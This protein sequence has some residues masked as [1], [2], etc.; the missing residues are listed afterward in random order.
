MLKKIRVPNLALPRVQAKCKA[1]LELADELDLYGPRSITQVELTKLLGNQTKPIG[2]YLRQGLERFGSYRP[3]ESGYSY[4]TNSEFCNHLREHLA[5]PPAPIL[6]V[7]KRV[8]RTFSPLKREELKKSGHRYYPW[9]TWMKSEKLEELFIA[10]YGQMHRYDIEAAQPTIVL[11]LYDQRLTSL[12]KYS[13]KHKV[14]TWRSYVNDRSTFRQTLAEHIF[15]PVQVV[16]DVLQS[17]TNGGY[18]TTSPKNPICRMLGI[19]STH[20]LLQHELYQGLIRDYRTMRSVLF[21]GEPVKGLSSRLYHS[22]E[23]VEDLIMECI[24][25]KLKVD[26]WFIHDG[27]FTHTR[28]QK[29]ELEAHVKNTLGFTIRLDEKSR[30]HSRELHV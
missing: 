7:A 27:F 4:R 20:R 21:P 10:Q 26:A 6:E 11:Q 13:E 9:W 23:R 28:I 30:F 2:A 1:L 19:I 29:A 14:Q 17:I 3:G 22:Y 5:T 24:S 18:A 16:K 12:H 15:E 25:K 8:N